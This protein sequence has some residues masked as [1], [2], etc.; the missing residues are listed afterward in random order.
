MAKNIKSKTIAGLSW[1]AIDSIASQGITFVIGIIL[2][3]MLTPKEFGTL[4]IAMIFV[5]LFNKF[6]D[7]GFSNSLIRKKDIEQIDYNTAFI[8]NVAVSVVMY[9]ACLALAPF[10]SSFF[11]FPDLTI[12]LRWLSIV[13]I[14]NALGIIQKTRLTR[15]IDFKTQTKVSI[16]SSIIS[17]IVG[18]SA[19]YWGCGV[20]SLVYQQITRQSLNTVL[21]W[22]FNRWHPQMQFSIDSFRQ[23]FSYGVKLLFSG[24][25][26]FTFNEAASIVIG[27]VY[28]PA[29]L[30]QY[31][32]AKQFSSIFSSNLSVIIERVTFPVLASFQYNKELLVA[33]YKKICKSLMLVSGFFMITLACTAESVVLILVGEKWAEAVLYL[34]IICFNDMFYP[35]KQVNLN[36]I[37]VTG[38]SDLVLRVTIIKRFIQVIPILLGFYS[39][40]MLLY[41]FVV[42]SVLGMV[43]NAYFASKCIPYSVVSQLKDLLKPLGV[44]LIAGVAMYAITFLNLN[45]YLQLLVQLLVGVSVFL[46]TVHLTKIA[47]YYFLKDTLLSALSKFKRH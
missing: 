44:C 42:S 4:G 45:I 33:Q 31:S 43:L 14:I 7:C 34:P 28:S 10:I 39:I 38:R 13:V 47:E 3:R 1:S 19:A 24:L 6:V 8:F 37:M 46:I 26:D 30:G 27:K 15:N 21:L 40:Y 25:I 41:G 35:V 16:S 18:I 17:G 9:L 12:V 2:A 22:I 29:T 11:N 23:Q 20:M 5:G 32:R 36:A